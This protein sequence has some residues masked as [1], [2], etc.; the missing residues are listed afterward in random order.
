MRWVDDLA[1][2]TNVPVLREGQGQDVLVDHDLDAAPGPFLTSL[3]VN[4]GGVSVVEYDEVGPASVAIFPRNWEVFWPLTKTARPW[5][6][7]SRRCW[8]RMSGLRDP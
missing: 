1:S 4:D 5:A 2:D 7:H 3:D 6:S 8:F